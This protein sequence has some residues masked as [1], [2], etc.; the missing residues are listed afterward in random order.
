LR[1][2]Y[3]RS[4][5]VSFGV[6]KSLEYSTLA[7]TLF[8]AREGNIAAELH[9]LGEGVADAAIVKLL[10]EHLPTVDLT[11]FAECRHA[12]ASRSAVRR[13]LAGRRLAASLRH[14]RRFCKPRA[15]AIRTREAGAPSRAVPPRRAP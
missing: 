9:W 3:C 10:R 5:L 11:V 14:H 13:F 8:L 2:P 1:I 12:M 6:R 4:E 15:A 7:D